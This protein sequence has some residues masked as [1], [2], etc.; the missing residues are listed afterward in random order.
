MEGENLKKKEKKKR[1]ESVAAHLGPSGGF[2]TRAGS[3][4]DKT[5]EDEKTETRRSGSSRRLE[6]LCYF[7]VCD[8]RHVSFI[9]FKKKEEK[10]SFC[11]SCWTMLAPTKPLL[12]TSPAQNKHLRFRSICSRAA[13][14]S[15]WCKNSVSPNKTSL[16]IS[17]LK[18]LL[19]VLM[20][21][22]RIIYNKTRKHK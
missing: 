11:R 3:A 22:G 19:H 9:P 5:K 1:M 16:L 18:M 14:P 17:F 15:W 6:Q 13:P 7:W 2:S 8:G 12:M 4:E 21:E 20:A 10:G